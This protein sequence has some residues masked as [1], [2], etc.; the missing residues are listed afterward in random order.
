[1][2]RCPTPFNPGAPGPILGQYEHQG[3]RNLPPAWGHRTRLRPRSHLPSP[4]SDGGL[5]ALHGHSPQTGQRV[6]GAR[7]MPGQAVRDLGVS[8]PPGQGRAEPRGAPARRWMYSGQTGGGAQAGEAET[9]ASVRELRRRRAV[10][11]GRRGLPVGWGGVYAHPTPL[12]TTAACPAPPDQSPSAPG[13]GRHP[14]EQQHL[15]GRGQG[16]WAGALGGS[17]KLGS[18]LEALRL[19]PSTCNS[20]RLSGSGRG[21]RAA[22]G[23]PRCLCG[24]QGKPCLGKASVCPS[25]QESPEEARCSQPGGDG[26]AGSLRPEGGLRSVCWVRRRGAERRGV[27]D[28][29]TLIPAAP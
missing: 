18:L 29:V 19:G 22:A 16:S 3:W 25:A 20:L 11:N 21:A 12:R 13:T 9:R 17:Q 10:G 26:A 27:S 24:M 4:R 23:C 15:Q 14:P 5:A 7:V 1:M 28:D 8:T 6:Q 2:T